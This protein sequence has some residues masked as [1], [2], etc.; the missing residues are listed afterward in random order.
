MIVLSVYGAISL[1]MDYAELRITDKENADAEREL[2]RAER[3][4]E[5]RRFAQQ[6]HKHY[7]QVCIK[8]LA[9][10]RIIFARGR[11]VK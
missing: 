1:I 5:I 6:A 8:R 10:R 9:E 4:E 11:E 3:L 7:Q 2:Q